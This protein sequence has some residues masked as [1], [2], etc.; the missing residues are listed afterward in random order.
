MHARC[1]LRDHLSRFGVGARFV[2]AFPLFPAS[3]LGKLGFTNLERRLR[4]EVS[5]SCKPF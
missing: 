2:G 3:V 4:C 5:A 1:I